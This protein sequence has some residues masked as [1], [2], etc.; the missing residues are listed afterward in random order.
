MRI[1]PV[2]AMGGPANLV[3][4]NPTLGSTDNIWLVNTDVDIDTDWTDY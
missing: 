2:A 4:E 1:L 3:W